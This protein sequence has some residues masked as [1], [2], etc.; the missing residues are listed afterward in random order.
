MLYMAKLG[1]TPEM[2]SGVSF[3]SF[4]DEQLIKD[5]DKATIK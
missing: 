1:Y 4:F 3:N 2:D 5:S